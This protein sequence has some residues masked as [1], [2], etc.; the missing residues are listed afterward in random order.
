VELEN[1]QAITNTERKE[2]NTGDL[3][4]KWVVSSGWVM[5]IIKSIHML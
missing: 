5:A 2:N 3:Y 1:K 4:R